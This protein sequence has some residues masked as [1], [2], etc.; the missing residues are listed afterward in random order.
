MRGKEVAVSF[1]VE[2]QFGYLEL[3]DL[4]QAFLE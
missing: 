1:E 3:P 2:L 4:T